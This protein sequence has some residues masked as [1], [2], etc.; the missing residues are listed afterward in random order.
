L[1]CRLLGV[2]HRRYEE[3]CGKAVT[4]IGGSLGRGYSGVE[5]GTRETGAVAWIGQKICDHCCGVGVEAIDARIRSDALDL[6][7]EIRQCSGIAELVVGAGKICR[8][9]I[10][11]GLCWMVGRPKGIDGLTVIADIDRGEAGQA[12]QGRNIFIPPDGTDAGD[13]PLAQP[14]DERSRIRVLLPAPLAASAA[15][16]FAAGL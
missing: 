8:S 11:K 10:A 6:D 14:H 15:F 1:L 2:E 9:G 16:T 13:R 3:A 5:V 7:G 4:Q 12:C